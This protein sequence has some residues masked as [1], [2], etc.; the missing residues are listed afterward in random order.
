MNR[1]SCINNNLLSY[2]GLWMWRWIHAWNNCLKL[3]V[4]EWRFTVIFFNYSKNINKNQSSQLHVKMM[5][6]WRHS[7][8]IFSY[9]SKL[10]NVC[11][12]AVITS[13]L[14]SLHISVMLW[15]R[16]RENG[17]GSS[18]NVKHVVFHFLKSI[19]NFSA[20]WPRITNNLE[21]NRR[22][23]W[24]RSSRHCKRN[25]VRNFIHLN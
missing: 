1:C 9:F 15:S 4:G 5:Y 25:L 2:R 3:M 21:F 23:F 22:R 24:S 20:G 6:K 14:S 19:G 16:T 10:Y 7:N 8:F 12:T 13:I 11:D 17:S 18:S